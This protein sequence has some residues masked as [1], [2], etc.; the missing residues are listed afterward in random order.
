M[1]RRPYKYHPK[2]LDISIFGRDPILKQLARSV[3]ENIIRGDTIWQMAMDMIY[4]N[5]N[6]GGLGLTGP[7]VFRPFQVMVID[8]QPSALHPGIRP[9][10]PIILINPEIIFTST[11]MSEA[12]ET[13]L[14]HPEMMGKVKRPKRAQV[15]FRDCEG[16]THTEMFDGLIARIFQQGYDLL[17]GMSFTEKFTPAKTVAAVA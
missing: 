1:N 15:R 2:H 3:P 10:Q 4:T 16:V 5:R 13:C 9:I 17:H 7:Q 8:P 14:S 11:I 6:E 12:T